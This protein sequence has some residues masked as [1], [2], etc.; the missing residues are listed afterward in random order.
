MGA[1]R[2]LPVPERTAIHRPQHM[3]LLLATSTLNDARRVEMDQGAPELGK[4][5]G[6]H[7]QSILKIVYPVS[8]LS[9]LGKLRLIKRR[10]Q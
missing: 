7:N 1:E 4:R 8:W 3:R 9:N 5:T 2:R 6:D 10:G